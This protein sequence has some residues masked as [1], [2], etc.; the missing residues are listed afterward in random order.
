MF[1]IKHKNKSVYY[2]E[3]TIILIAVLHKLCIPAIK[4]GN[5]TRLQW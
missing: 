4:Q 5:L 1:G 2:N 3:V